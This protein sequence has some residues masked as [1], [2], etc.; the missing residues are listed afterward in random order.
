MAENRIV[1]DYG[2]FEGLVLLGARNTEYGTDITYDALKS[3]EPEL[4]LV[5]RYD[6]YSDFDQ[7]KSM[8]IPN[9]EG[10]V[11]K[12]SN[13]S[14]MKIKFEEYLRLHRIMTNVSTKSIWEFLSSDNTTS[15]EELLNGVPD[16]FYDKIQKYIA[17]LNRDFYEIQEYCGKYFDNILENYDQELP[18]G[19]T[20][21]EIINKVIEPQYHGIMWSMYNNRSYSSN[22]WRIL[23]PKFETL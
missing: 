7:L 18:D 10:F 14:R 13:G 22:I 21:S 11:I 19:K 5:K 9:E 8:N 3:L 20:Y 1:V 23:K 17:K 16:E 2:E 12:F 6:G 15:L 4:N